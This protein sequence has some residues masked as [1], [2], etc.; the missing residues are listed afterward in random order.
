MLLH[1]VFGEGID[2]LQEAVE[3][4]TQFIIIVIELTDIISKDADDHILLKKLSKQMIP[5]QYAHS[6]LQ[7]SIHV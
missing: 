1:G 4:Y 3:M 7:V 2:H 5:H 6:L